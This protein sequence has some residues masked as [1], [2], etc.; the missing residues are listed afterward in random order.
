MKNL[1]SKRGRPYLRRGTRQPVAH[2][3][4]AWREFLGWTQERLAEET[5]LSVAVISAYERGAA[6][7]S[8][9]ALADI[10]AALGQ[11]RGVILDVD[12]HKVK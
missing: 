10:A 7:P 12:P 11:P 3:I 8:L 6:N 2:K 9:E 5:G 4:R 1:Q